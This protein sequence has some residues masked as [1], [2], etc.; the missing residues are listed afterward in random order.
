MWQH[1][2]LLSFGFA[3]CTRPT[4]VAL[5]FVR[6]GMRLQDTFLAQT[7]R[8][9]WGVGLCF[10][11]ETRSFDLYF[12]S[13]F[14]RRGVFTS[15]CPPI[16]YRISFFCFALRLE[17]AGTLV[18]QLRGYRLLGW[19]RP[20][21]QVRSDLKSRVFW[22]PAGKLR[23]GSTRGSRDPRVFGYPPVLHPLTAALLA[24]VR[25]PLIMEPL[26]RFP[27]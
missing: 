2:C 9:S 3:S 26:L 4:C 1:T 23:N 5:A 27:S 22:E 12:F 21:S 25:G 18:F 17:T 24:L 19:V 14:L 15:S 8:G 7:E 11:C 20:V 6:I 16:V 10:L 13:R